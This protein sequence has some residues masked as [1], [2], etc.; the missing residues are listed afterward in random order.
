ML[1]VNSQSRRSAATRRRGTAVMEAALIFPM[2]IFLTFGSIE[3]GYYF[4]AKHSFQGAAREGARRSIV[5]GETNASVTT[6]VSESMTAAGFLPGTYTVAIRNPADT[7]NVDIATAAP[8]TSIMVKVSAPL[9][10]V[11]LMS[12]LMLKATNSD[13]SARM[14]AG[15]TVMRKEG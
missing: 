6:V 12:P 4:F 9:S 13:G 3:F 15:Q 7:G 10:S 2:L 5:T 14:V 11:R 8:G 1:S